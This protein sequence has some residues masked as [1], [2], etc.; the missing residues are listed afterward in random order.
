V[1]GAILDPAMVKPL[2]GRLDTHSK[3][4]RF[5]STALRLL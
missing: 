1:T 2:H 4:S 5:S 3:N